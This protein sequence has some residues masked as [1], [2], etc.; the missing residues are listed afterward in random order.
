[1]IEIQPAPAGANPDTSFGILID[2]KNHIAADGF[3]VSGIVTIACELFC[4]GVE[5]IQAAFPGANPE[6][7]FAIFINGID[8]GS[9]QAVRVPRLGLVMD[10]RLSFPLEEIQTGNGAQP[11]II[12]AI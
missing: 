12:L 2:G 1:M 9:T 11:E 10:E 3:F 4:F 7:A 8:A 5:P 6:V